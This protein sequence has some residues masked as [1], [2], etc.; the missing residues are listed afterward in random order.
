MTPGPSTNYKLQ[1][2]NYKLQITLLTLARSVERLSEE[3]AAPGLL[4][5]TGVGLLVRI[6]IIDTMSSCDSWSNI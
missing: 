5:G 1:I 6:L 3:E 2:T 4:E